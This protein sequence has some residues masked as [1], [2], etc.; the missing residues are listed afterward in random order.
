M[1]AKELKE[2]LTVEHI[3]DLMADFDTEPRFGRSDNE[4]IFRT[5]CHG[6]DSHKLY[7]YKNTMNFHCYTHCG[8]MDILQLV[9]NI[10]G[11]DLPQAINYIADRFGFK[12]TEF[13]Y[14]FGEQK[15]DLVDW[16]IINKYKTKQTKTDAW[17]EFRVIDEKVFNNFYNF[18]HKSFLLDGISKKAMDKFEIKF[19]ILNNR[20]IIPHRYTNGDLV[21]IRCR[22]LEE[23]L[24][25]TGRK[26]MPIVLDGKTLSAP[27]GQYFYGLY[28]NIENI[29]R[30]KK[31]VLVES[32]KA[33][34]QFETMY[35][36]NNIALALSSSN[37]SQFQIDI[38]KEL[39]IEEVIIALDKE[40]E[41]SGIRE[42][43]IYAMKVDKSIVSR[44][45][46]FNVSVIWD[47][48]GLINKKD[49]PLDKGK[50]VFERLYNDRIDKHRWEKMINEVC[51]K[52]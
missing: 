9:Q 36:N 35:P 5:V 24:I 27:T 51:I 48:N 25:N 34:M 7:F 15:T 47:F 21:A 3:L 38:L 31:V 1:N 13:H 46:L 30:T 16:D 26:Y 42:E 32:E 43:M 14:G 37:L 4:L 49:S 23:Y 39:G 20:I 17:K 18:Y 8:S 52:R 44:L 45:G 40:Y 2:K 41:R 29:K 12:Y 28:Q 33:V 10:M 22:N 19:D 11:F 50:D 6:G